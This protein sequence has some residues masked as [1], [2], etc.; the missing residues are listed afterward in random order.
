MFFLSSNN[1]LTEGVYLSSYC[2]LFTA[3]KNAIRKIMATK[4]EKEIR[5]TIADTKVT[6]FFLL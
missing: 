5:I 2:P 1:I 4:S 3:H 6:L